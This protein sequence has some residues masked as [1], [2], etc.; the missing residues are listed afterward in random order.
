M[1]FIPNFSISQSIGNPSIINLADTSTGTDGTIV[2]R[3]VYLTKDT[4]LTLVPIG[5]TTTFITW[6][7]A[8]PTIALN[9]LDKDYSLSILVNWLDVSS[10]ILYFK[11]IIANFNMYNSDFNYSLVSDEANGLASLNSS[12]WLQSRMRLYLSLRDAVTSITDMSSV[13]NGQNANDRGTFLRQNLNNF[14]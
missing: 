9:V 14:Y 7:L 6:L 5:T 1:P 10:N 2:S 13:T 12:N 11:T 3:V 4:G 8:N